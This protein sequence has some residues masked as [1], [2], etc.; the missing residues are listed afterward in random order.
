MSLLVATHDVMRLHE[1]GEGHPERPDRLLAVWDGIKGAGLG[2]A[3]EWLE[4]TDAPP[5]VLERIHPRHMLESLASMAKAGGG[6]IDPDTWVSAQSSDAAVKAAGAGLD[7]I[8]ALD[9]GDADVGWSVVRPPGHHALANK[10]MGFC[11]INN[12]AVAA[13]FLADR[14]ERVA[15]IDV[16]AHHGNGTQDIFY[17]DPDVLFVSLHQYP[18]Y[19]FTGRP[20][21]V[22]EG[23]GRGTTVNIALPAGTTGRAYRYAIEQVVA[24]VVSRHKPDWILVSAG[25]DGHQQDPITE[26]GLSSA[27]YADMV[28]DI[29][30]LA[31]KGR[32]LLFLEGGYDLQALRD[33]AGAVVASSIGEFY[34]PERPT[35]GGPGEDMVDMARAIHLGGGSGDL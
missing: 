24:P 28:K 2:D 10:Q 21:E 23:A 29:L 19:P 27:D 3:V 8:A 4:A 22:G 14:G 35:T 13:R 17:Q 9:R 7:L 15:I 5:E 32:R 20:D 34:R 25:F 1:P 18:W 26:M 11:L 31:K 16:D 33:C 6:S 12:V 30:Q